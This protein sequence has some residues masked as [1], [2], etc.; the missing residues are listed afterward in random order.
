MATLDLI[1]PVF[2][3]GE[4]ALRFH[5][6]LSKT[7]QNVNYS[8]RFIYVN[9]GS[10]DNTSEILKQIASADSR[11]IYLE[12]SRNF[13]H[14]AALSAGM[15][16]ASADAVITMDGDGEHP[17]EIIPEMLRLYESGY[18]VVQTQREDQ[19]RTGFLLKT[20][21]AHAFYWLIS[22]LGEM[23]ITPGSADFRLLSKRAFTALRQLPEYHR[24]YRGMVHWIGFRSVILPYV[25]SSRIA[26]KSKYTL[27]KMLRLARDGMFSFSLVPL[28]LGLVLGS[29]FLLLACAEVVYVL[30][31]WF[32]GE[33]SRLVPGWSSLMVM[34][35]VSSGISMLIIGILGIYTGMIFQEV[36]RRPVYLV[37]SREPAKASAAGEDHGDLQMSMK[38]PPLDG[39]AS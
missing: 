31:F 5:Q 20:I 15:D 13:G 24:F 4:S 16:I 8:L 38:N 3:E 12:L 17:P 9:D 29:L 25:P 19:H 26:G 32:R 14:Q 30:A 22:K 23:T 37:Q 11:V 39:E 27:R 33:S 10:K 2:N 18:D 21:T 35:T 6:I 7:L 34:L 28:R 36:K 1:I